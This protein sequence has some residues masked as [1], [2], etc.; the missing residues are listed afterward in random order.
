MALMGRVWP[1]G[2]FAIAVKQKLRVRPCKP[3]KPREQNEILNLTVE[4]RQIF[5]EEWATSKTAGPAP[6]EFLPEDPNSEVGAIAALG[7]SDASNSHRK[8]LRGSSGLT[9]YARK[10]LRNCAWLLGR[11]CKKYELGMITTTLPPMSVEDERKA[12]AS[13]AEIMRQFTQ[14]LGRKLLA[15]GS[16]PWV[17]GCCEIQLERQQACGGLPL[18]SH[19]LCQTR[20][21]KT[22]V[23]SPSDIQHIWKQT[24]LHVANIDGAYVWDSSTRVETVRKN[25]ESYLAKYISKGAVAPGVELSIS[26]SLLPK[27]WWYATGGIKKAVKKLVRYLPEP[28]ADFLYWLWRNAD[29]AMV[30]RF[31]VCPNPDRTSVPIAWVGKLNNRGWIMLR[32]VWFQMAVPPNYNA[33]SAVG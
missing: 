23:F 31:D 7:L 27:N 3:A 11:Q 13:W 9:G 2:E 22:F 30:Y 25:C 19:L 10:M 1:N 26:G 12:I 28:D 33:S 18:H 24:V 20:S 17:V 21:K 8:N 4:E 5:W 16:S 6:S 32:S 29:W 15:A 14:A